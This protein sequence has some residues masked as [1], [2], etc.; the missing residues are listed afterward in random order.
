[1]TTP[2]ALRA[3]TAAEPKPNV[4]QSTATISKWITSVLG[5]GQDGAGAIY[6]LNM[7]IFAGTDDT[8][9]IS[10]TSAELGSAYYGWYKAW[11]SPALE[12]QT[13]AGT[14]S[15]SLDWNEGNIAHNTFPR[16]FLYVWKAD[17]TGVRG[18]LYSEINSAVEADISDA[19]QQVFF[20]SVALSSVATLA[21][22][23]IVIE[24][25]GYDN[26]TK[27]ASYLHALNFDGTNAGGRNSRMSFSQD[28]RF[29]TAPRTQGIVI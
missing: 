8:Q 29:L 1:M 16:I 24:I 28:L 14:W 11:I 22:D 3:S 26:N 12:A 19:T 10:E 13:I 21:G 23:R 5:G 9:T 20:S 2:L 18:T 6:P 15:L 25:M 27:T 4:R 17:D 7:S